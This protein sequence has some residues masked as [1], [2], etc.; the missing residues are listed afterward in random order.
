MNT[1]M[2]LL[3]QG[4]GD[5]TG[6]VCCA[7]IIIF[8]VAIIIVISKAAKEQAKERNAARDA[9]FNALRRLKAN[10][11]S[12]DL[13]QNTLELGRVYSNLTRNKAGVTVYDEVALSNDINA[14]CA[15][16]ATLVANRPI[17]ATT[18]EARLRQLAELKSNGLISEEEY[19]ARRNK[20]LD[21][22]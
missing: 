3:W 6:F 13:R 20:I 9:Y 21:E 1:Q 18:T 22:V 16:A 10:P 2:L 14:A 7:G 15:G 4:G 11:T 5:S 12:A 17:Q 19:T 8:V